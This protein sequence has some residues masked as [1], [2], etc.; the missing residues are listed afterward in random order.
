MKAN[1]PDR[2]TYYKNISEQCLIGAVHSNRKIPSS[3]THAHS[4]LDLYEFPYS[5][6]HKSRY[7]KECWKP[8]TI[9]FNSIYCSA[10]FRSSSFV[11]KRKKYLRF[12]TTEGRLNIEQ[13]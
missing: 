8:V 2:A 12:E 10:F 1:N 13:F 3:F 7:F 6:E 5:I 4:V 11:F 9:D